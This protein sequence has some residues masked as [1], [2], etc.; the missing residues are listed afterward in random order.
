MMRLLTTVALLSCTA[1]SA[2]AQT[3]TETEEKT[4]WQRW[5]G[6]IGG[7]LNIENGN[8]KSNSIETDVRGKY[9][10]DVWSDLIELESNYRKENNVRTRENYRAYNRLDRNLNE[11]EFIFLGLLY[12]KDS[13]AGYDQRTSETVGYGRKVIE[14]ENMNLEVLGSVGMRQTEYTDNTDENEMIVQPEARF[15]WQIT[16]TLGFGQNL[17]FTIGE[18]NTVTRSRTELTN[19]LIGNLNLRLQLDV[20][21]NSDVP[22]GTKKTDTNFSANLVY[23]F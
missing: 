1:F 23:K 5:S 8:T 9:E 12:E 3:P 19:Q 16:P 18:E 7:G 22:D 10:G 20:E 17:S 14:R 11:K 4:Y 13:F 15:K 21:N 6:E 2:Y